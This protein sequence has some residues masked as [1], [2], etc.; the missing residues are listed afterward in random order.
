MDQVAESDRRDLDPAQWVNRYGD[1]LFQYALKRLR[2]TESAEE[3]VQETFVAGLRYRDQYAQRGEE[4]AWLLGILKRKIVD[5]VRAR[6]RQKTFDVADDDHDIS[7]VLF[8][9][10]GRWKGDPRICGCAPHQRLESQEFWEAFRSC[11]EGLPPRQADVFSLRELDAKSSEEVCKDLEITPSNL[12]VLLHR[13]RLRLAHCLKS[14]WHA[15]ESP[16]P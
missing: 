7:N 8:D 9:H 14:R 3:A 1:Y 4:R 11:L 12:W 15:E 10:R 6:A 16:A 2:S 13:A 5:V